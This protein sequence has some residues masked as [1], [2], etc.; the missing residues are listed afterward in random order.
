MTTTPKTVARVGAL[1]RKAESTANHREAEAFTAMTQ[2][3]ATS[4]RFDLAVARTCSPPP[5]PVR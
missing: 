1:L 4:I 2:R 5:E 3:L